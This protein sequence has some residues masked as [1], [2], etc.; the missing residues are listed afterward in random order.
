[1][2]FY[3]NNFSC[4]YATIGGFWD[5]RGAI[6]IPLNVFINYSQPENVLVPKADCQLAYF[7]KVLK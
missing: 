6:K 7:K 5:G 3:F 2:T 1:M 4:T